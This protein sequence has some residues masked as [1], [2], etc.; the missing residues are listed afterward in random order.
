MR[1]AGHVI[2]GAVQQLLAGLRQFSVF[3]QN[4]QTV[5][6]PFLVVLK[7]PV[8]LIHL[9]GIHDLGHLQAR[10]GVMHAGNDESGVKDAFHWSWVDT[11]GGPE[12]F[13]GRIER[14]RL[15][16]TEREQEQMSDL[17]HDA[18]CGFKNGLT[19]PSRIDKD[20]TPQFEYG[21]ADIACIQMVRIARDKDDFRQNR[22]DFRKT[23]R[24]KPAQN[25]ERLP[26]ACSVKTD[27]FA[28]GGDKQRRRFLN[29]G[30][31]PV[32]FEARRPEPG[33]TIGADVEITGS[34]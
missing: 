21:Y 10:Q 14:E 4:S 16:Q 28:V 32:P 13:G 33:F 25:T 17:M 29:L 31:A 2:P 12:P 6:E 23:F 22:V 1:S 8:C 27:L 20:G 18:F 30:M 26:Q 24:R 19:V 11:Q 7:T 9:V 34:E 15:I 3:P 5:G